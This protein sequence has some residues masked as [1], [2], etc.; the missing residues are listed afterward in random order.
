MR[1]THC[2]C[3]KGCPPWR[4]T[5]MRSMMM[6]SYM[7]NL[8]L[9]YPRR[10]RWHSIVVTPVA[11]VISP[12]MPQSP[13]YCRDSRHLQPRNAIK[14]WSSSSDDALLSILNVAATNNA[15]MTWLL[16]SHYY[17][18]VFQVT[19]QIILQRSSPLLSAT[20]PPKDEWPAHWA[21]TTLTGTPFESKHLANYSKD[22]RIFLDPITPRTGGLQYWN[23]I[24]SQLPLIPM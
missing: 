7:L 19:G 8:S 21:H 4:L 12:A 5:R 16:L 15:T 17:C 11:Q 22:S 23:V 24:L 10:C 2:H 13:H 14:P 18:S 20:S 3:P 9:T 1:W 6:P